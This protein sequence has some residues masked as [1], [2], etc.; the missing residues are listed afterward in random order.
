MCGGVGF[1][2]PE[3]GKERP[4]LE[5]PVCCFHRVA[6]PLGDD[7]EVRVQAQPRRKVPRLQVIAGKQRRAAPR[8]AAPVAKV[9]RPP[10]A[11][12]RLVHEEFLVGAVDVASVEAIR[13]HRRRRQSTNERVRRLL[14]AA[15]VVFHRR[16]ARNVLLLDRLVDRLVG[17]A[18]RGRRGRGRRRRVRQRGGLVVLGLDG[19]GLWQRERFARRG[20]ELVDFSEVATD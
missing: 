3:G 19:G 15:V 1:R 4:C 12:R 11:L 20:A 14:R 8:G 7:A 9:A 13:G 2:G 17:G 5:I 18:C 6:P 16:V 10:R